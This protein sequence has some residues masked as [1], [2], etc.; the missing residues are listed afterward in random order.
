M[1]SNRVK[2]FNSVNIGAQNWGS[3][4]STDG[5]VDI[6]SVQTVSNKVFVNCTFSGSNPAV[7]ALQLFKGIILGQFTLPGMLA[8][9]PNMAASIQAALAV[10]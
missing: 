5:F 4:P 8:C 3:V 6:D 9:A 10:S 2:V 7:L 1:A